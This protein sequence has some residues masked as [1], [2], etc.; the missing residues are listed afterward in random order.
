[1]NKERIIL[2]LVLICL[3]S[4]TIAMTQVPYND[5]CLY[6]NS[7]YSDA[8]ICNATFKTRITP[9]NMLENLNHNIISLGMSSNDPNMLE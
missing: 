8:N 3:Y 5:I 9:T 6:D 7:V 2:L 4:I 1:M